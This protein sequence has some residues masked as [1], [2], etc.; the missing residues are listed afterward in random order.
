MFET[1]EGKKARWMEGAD[2]RARLGGYTRVL[3]DLGTGDGRFVLD[4]ARRSPE[5][6]AIGI[7][8]CRENLLDASRKL[9]PNAL[10]VIANA[11]GLPA[12]L[13][14]L[15]GQVTINFP[16]GSLLS[17]L[18]TADPGL[19]ESLRRVM[20]PGASLSVRLN[21]SALAEQGCDLITGGARVRETL[22]QAGF[23]IKPPALLR[24]VDLRTC[25]TTWA[26][27]LAYGRRPEAV[28]LAGRI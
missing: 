22:A 14:G 4:S 19:L 18:L 20:Q 15:A 8:A 28:A 26:K 6:F 16:W 11:A 7:D 23:A 3:I 21:A 17:G 24:S 25:P 10:F 5:L 9:A 27:K 1:I 13:D 2:L 12:E